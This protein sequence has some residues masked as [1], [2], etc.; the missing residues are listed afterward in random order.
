[1]TKKPVKMYSTKIGNVQ[2]NFH[3]QRKIFLIVFKKPDTKRETHLHLRLNAHSHGSM[4]QIKQ[5]K[6]TY[7]AEN[8]KKTKVAETVA[9]SSISVRLFNLA[10]M[11]P[12]LQLFFIINDSINFS[13]TTWFWY[14][15]SFT[16][17]FECKLY[18]TVI[19]EIIS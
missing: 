7:L 9:S 6:I 1:M 19:T 15:W 17:L 8:T 14:H 13:T 10:N 3:I 5:D 4:K 12:Y 11:H 18:K 2:Q 16:C